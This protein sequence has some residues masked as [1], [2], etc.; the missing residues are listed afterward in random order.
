M[1]SDK[2]GPPTQDAWL[3]QSQLNPFS[4]TGTLEMDEQ[5]LRF[6]LDEDSAKLTTISWLEKELGRSDLRDRL[7]Q[8]DKVVAFELSRPQLKV[9]WPKQ[10]MGSAMK[11]SNPGS[12]EW[13]VSL[14]LPS[15]SLYSTYK[16]FKVRSVAKEW[17]KALAA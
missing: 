14:V 12:R 16:A 17:K 13:L 2:Q 7:K 4:I 10:F 15:G 8:G 11:V 9:E 6:V 5:S 3:M 1:S